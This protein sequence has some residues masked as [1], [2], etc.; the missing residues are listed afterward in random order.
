MESLVA[1]LLV[2]VVVCLGPGLLLLL[3]ARVLRRPARP[4][5][6]LP[7]DVVWTDDDEIAARHHT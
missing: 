6:P 4:P 1:V 7:H 3:L 5:R 2:M